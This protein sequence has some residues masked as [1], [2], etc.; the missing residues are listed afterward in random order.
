MNVMSDAQRAAYD[1]LK[2]TP[3]EC[4]NPIVR[5]NANAAWR[6][7]VVNKDKETS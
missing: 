6:Q 4:P 7:Y 3:A 2:L 1:R 5:R